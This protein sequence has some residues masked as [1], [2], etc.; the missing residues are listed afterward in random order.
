MQLCVV[1]LLVNGSVAHSAAVGLP[2]LQ[3]GKCLGRPAA[4]GTSRRAAGQACPCDHLRQ[5]INCWLIGICQEVL[6]SAK[7]SYSCNCLF[8]TVHHVARLVS[9]PRQVSYCRNSGALRRPTRARAHHG[10]SRPVRFSRLVQRDA[11]ASVSRTRWTPECAVRPGG[12]ALSLRQ[13][14]ANTVLTSQT[15]RS[16]L[17]VLVASGQVHDDNGRQ[18]RRS[19]NEHSAFDGI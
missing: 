19:S 12:A 16:C 10:R 4:Y 5:L 7:G 11:P 8:G 15:R 2:A 6:R 17:H 1:E 3:R 18:E 9:S 14:S 13:N